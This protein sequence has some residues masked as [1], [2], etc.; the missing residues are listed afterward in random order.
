M[1]WYKKPS[2]KTK[3]KLTGRENVWCPQGW[4]RGSVSRSSGQSVLS[5]AFKNISRLRP[6]TE[7]LLWRHRE[8]NLGKA[9]F[10]EAG[11]QLVKEGNGRQ[12]ETPL[13][14]SGCG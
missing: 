7:C 10:P 9:G 8:G 5:T 6:S 11:L 3:V 1:A 13:R 14:E 4:E 2:K 12:V